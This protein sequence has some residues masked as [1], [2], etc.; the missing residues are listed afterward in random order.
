VTGFTTALFRT[1]FVS[2]VVTSLKTQY[3]FS[4]Q[5]APFWPVNPPKGSLPAIVTGTFTVDVNKVGQGVDETVNL[6][7]F[8]GQ[9]LDL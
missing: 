5:N 4:L 7:A 6:A 3:Q 9:E 1:P 8:A 2:M